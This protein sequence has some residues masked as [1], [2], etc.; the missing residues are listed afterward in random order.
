[1]YVGFI[2]YVLSYCHLSIAREKSGIYTRPAVGS[3][4]CQPAADVMTSW[5]SN[6]SNSKLKRKVIF[7]GDKSDIFRDCNSM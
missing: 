5:W 3:V 6:C 4:N 2:F 1:M 7:Y